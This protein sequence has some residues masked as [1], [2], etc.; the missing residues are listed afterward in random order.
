MQVP[1]P[2]IFGVATKSLTVVIPAYN[3]EKRLPS[4]LEETL[5]CMRD[6]RPCFAHGTFQGAL[7]THSIVAHLETNELSNALV[8]HGPYGQPQHL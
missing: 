1:V 4:T 8:M 2:S 3:E 5:R 6:G 7:G